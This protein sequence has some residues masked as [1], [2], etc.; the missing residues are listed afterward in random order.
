MNE[1]EIRAEA[2]K[3]GMQLRRKGKKRAYKN[4]ETADG[5]PILDYFHPHIRMRASTRGRRRS[6][7]CS[8]SRSQSTSGAR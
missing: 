8:V 4:A 5:Q 1:A 2:E 7:D 6:T 3:I